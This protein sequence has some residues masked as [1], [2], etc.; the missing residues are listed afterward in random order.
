[1]SFCIHLMSSVNPLDSFHLCSTAGIIND[2]SNFQLLKDSTVAVIRA[3]IDL[4]SGL[5]Y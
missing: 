1:M 4:D 2:L 3:V 5:K